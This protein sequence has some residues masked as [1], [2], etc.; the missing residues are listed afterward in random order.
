MAYT[1]IISLERAKTYLRIDDTQ[2]ETDSEINSMLIAAFRY[3]EK[4][5]NIIFVAKD[6]LYDVVDGTVSVYDH[7]I[8][9]EV[10]EGL[11]SKKKRLY[12][13]YCAPINV[14]TIELNVGYVDP[15]DIDEDILELVLMIT[16]TMYYEQ[17]TDQSFKELLPSW[18]VE[19][20]NTNRRFIL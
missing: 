5:T 16:K 1:D 3:V 11:E 17:E 15:L 13:I 10:T 7:P 19:T 4:T 2:N 18:A 20:L 6:K 9:S 8:N 12:T 14:D